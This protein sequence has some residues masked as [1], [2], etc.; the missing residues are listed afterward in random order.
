MD[1]E[2]LRGRVAIHAALAD[3][4]RLEIVDELALSDRSP[5][6]LGASLEIGSNLLAHHLGV[7]QETGL[8]ERSPSAGD[9]RKRYVRLVPDA[10][11]LIAEPVATLLARHVLFVCTANSARSQLAAAVWNARHEVPASS[12][13][14]RP[15]ARIHPGAVKAASRVGLDL[16]GAGTRSIGEVTE[17]PDLVVS[18]CDIAREEL[19]ALP[20]GARLLHWSIPDPALQESPAAFDEAL[21]LITVRVES[22]VP[23][24][25]PPRRRG[26]SRP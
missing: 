15:A 3:P 12:A 1:V 21:R 25:R 7:L 8:V 13:G 19:R 11:A 23:R 18:V 16:R 4:H 5:S 24:V 2:S 26:R 17:R 20:E 14:T 22:L 10:L 9:R 6:E